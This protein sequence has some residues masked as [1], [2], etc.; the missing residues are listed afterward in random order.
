MYK[1]SLKSSTAK[2][3][4]R[5]ITPLPSVAEEEFRKLISREDLIGAKAMAVLSLNNKQ[6]MCHRFDRFAGSKDY[7]APDAEIRLFH[8]DI[9]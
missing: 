2:L 7:V 5:T 4:S 1:I 9:K 6:L 8:D 3:A